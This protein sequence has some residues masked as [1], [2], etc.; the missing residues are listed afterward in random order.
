MPHAWLLTGP[1]GVGKATLA[2]RLARFVLAASRAPETAPGRSGTAENVTPTLDIPSGSSAGH[3]VRKG[4]HPDLIIVERT[5]NDRT[6]KLHR[7]IVVGDIATLSHRLRL[8]SSAGGWQVAI[9]DSADDMNR[10]AANAFAEDPR[11]TAETDL[12]SCW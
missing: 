11:G 7:D 12:C 5:V 4:S 3:L 1:R 8:T 9:I 10:N 2:Y 6:G